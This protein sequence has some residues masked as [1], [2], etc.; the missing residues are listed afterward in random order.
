MST[1]QPSSLHGAAL[2]T[3]DGHFHVPS[4]TT[5]PFEEWIV[6]GRCY[7]LE[8]GQ[9]FYCPKCGGR[10]K[11]KKHYERDGRIRAE[12]GSIIDSAGTTKCINPQCL[13]TG[14]SFVWRIDG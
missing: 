8:T 4:G 10:G 1:D 13:L 2:P 12:D 11:P 6:S 3:F 5:I 14:S 7:G 9:E